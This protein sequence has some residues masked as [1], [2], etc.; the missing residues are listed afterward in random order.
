MLRIQG[1]VDDDWHWSKRLNFWF[2]ATLLTLIVLIK[3]GLGPIVYPR[4]KFR[5]A[6]VIVTEEELGGEVKVL[7]KDRLKMRRKRLFYIGSEYDKPGAISCWLWGRVGAKK[8]G[9]LANGGIVLRSGG[10]SKYQ[11]NR[12]SGNMVRVIG[13]DGSA[14]SHVYQFN[15]KKK[16]RLGLSPN[17]FIEFKEIK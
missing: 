4:F 8:Q 15:G 2:W 7:F 13:L 11:S 1:E 9:G 16:V 5:Y 3:W 6:D 12:A 14:L 10:K 17:Q